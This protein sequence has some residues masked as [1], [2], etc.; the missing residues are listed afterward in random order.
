MQPM[1]PGSVFPVLC[2]QCKRCWVSEVGAV[3]LFIFLAWPL[4][5]RSSGI[6]QAFHNV[7]CQSCS[8]MTKTNRWNYKD[9][10]PDIHSVLAMYKLFNAMMFSLLTPRVILSEKN[11]IWPQNYLLLTTL[12][13]FKRQNQYAHS[14]PYTYWL[15]VQKACHKWS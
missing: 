11:H 2:P 3:L 7:F 15:S 4:R 8:N 12:F 13:H 9:C 5:P 14:H 6:Y 10:S 1:F